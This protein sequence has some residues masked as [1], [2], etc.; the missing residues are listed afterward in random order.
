MF[1]SYSK[2]QSGKVIQERPQSSRPTKMRDLGNTWNNVL[3]VIAWESK[4]SEADKNKG[5]WDEKIVSSS[6]K[7]QEDLACSS[8]LPWFT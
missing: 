8:A 1:A 4:G 5:E 2:I 7:Q 6:W 3:F